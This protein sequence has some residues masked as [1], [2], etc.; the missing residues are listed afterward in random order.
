MKISKRLS[1]TA[2]LLSA[3]LL[4]TNLNANTAFLNDPVLNQATIIGTVFHDANR[5]GHLDAGE[6]GIP[7]VRLATV[8]GLLIETDGYGRFHIPD[9]VF[10]NSPFGQKRLLKIDLHSLPQGAKFTTENPRLLRISNAGLNKMNFGV[11]F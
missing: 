3:S 4:I 11:T 5:N 6:T 7:G 2:L 10:G 1:Q 9:N 8:T